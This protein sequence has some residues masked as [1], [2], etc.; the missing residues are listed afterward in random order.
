MQK[1]DCC[2]M[3]H[4]NRQGMPADCGLKTLKLKEGDIICKV[5]GGT[6][7]CIGKEREITSSPICSTPQHQVA[8]WT[9]K[10]MHQ[11]LC[12]LRVTVRVIGYCGFQ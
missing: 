11:N 1:I 10:E 7:L 5:K 12:A 3:V 8:L 2:G 6:I 9:K 4:H